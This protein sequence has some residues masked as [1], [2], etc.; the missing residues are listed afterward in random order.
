MLFII[1]FMRNYNRAYYKEPSANMNSIN[2][3][4]LTISESLHQMA[5]QLIFKR[6]K[7]D[8]KSGERLQC[9]LFPCRTPQD[10]FAKKS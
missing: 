9:T 6:E 7:N 10:R 4:N 1:T 5:F 2:W 8:P 3:Y